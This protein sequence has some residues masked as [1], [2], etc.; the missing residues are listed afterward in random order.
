MFNR[1][2]NAK[3]VVMTEYHQKNVA[4]T[5]AAGIAR[6]AALRGASNQPIGQVIQCWDVTL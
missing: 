6:L 5:S 4:Q 1:Y 2:R 3:T